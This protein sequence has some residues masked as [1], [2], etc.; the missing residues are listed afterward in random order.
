MSA[1]LAL[2]QALKDGWYLDPEDPPT[3]FGPNYELVLFYDGEPEV[4]KSRAEILA[5]ARAAKAA[6]KQEEVA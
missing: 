2:A 6:K 3:E 1:S 5:A 4:K